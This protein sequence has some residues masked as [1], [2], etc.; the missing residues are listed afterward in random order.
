MGLDYVAQLGVPLDKLTAALYNTAFTDDERDD[1]GKLLEWRGY[2]L[3]NDYTIGVWNSP[4]WFLVFLEA[5]MRSGSIST[6]NQ[7]ELDFFTI[8]VRDKLD[9]GDVQMRVIVF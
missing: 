4:R 5:D 2:K 9:A 1:E 6:I 3:F 7:A 8:M